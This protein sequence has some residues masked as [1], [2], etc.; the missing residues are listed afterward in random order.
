MKANHIIL[1][2]LKELAANNSKD[3]MDINR[4]KYLDAK[5]QWLS[6]IQEILNLLNLLENNNYSHVEP[7]NCISRITN[8][9]MYRPEMPVYKD[10]FTFSVMDQKDAFS[11][12]HISVGAENSFV[13][14]GYHNPDKDTLKNIREAIDFNGEVFDK[15]LNNYEFK[16]L[17]GGLSDHTNK[18]KTSPRGYAKDH[19]YVEYLRYKNFTVAKNLTY[20]EI[21][22]VN[23]LNTLKQAYLISEPF[24]DYLKRCNS[25]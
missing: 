9:R 13:G 22:S 14:F 19:P 1:D 17:F 10:F 2:F 20:D 3:W 4:K 16:S 5:D 11:P 21:T 23:F 6:Q 24:R 8:N 7:K 18:L 15:I 12:I 25:I